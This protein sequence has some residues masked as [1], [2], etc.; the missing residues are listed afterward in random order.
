MSEHIA[1]ESSEIRAQLGDL[2]NAASEWTGK[3]CGSN[4]K[5]AIN[6]CFPRDL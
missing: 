1:I 4:G 2:S 5:S 3:E 6:G